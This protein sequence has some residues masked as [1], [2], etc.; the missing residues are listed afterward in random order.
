MD[1]TQRARQLRRDSTDVERKLWSRLR[2]R[3]LCNLKFRRQAAIGPYYVD[4]LCHDR[5][6]VVE[7]DGGQHSAEA[8]AAR[9]AYLAGKGYRVIRFWNNEVSEN[10]D[11]VLERIARE[12]DFSLRE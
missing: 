5:R 4:F 12:A 11:G 3:G 8:E 1:R 10:I 2:N 7:L 9:T 6:L